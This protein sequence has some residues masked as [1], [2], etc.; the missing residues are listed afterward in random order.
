MVLFPFLAFLAF[1]F[2]SGNTRREPNW[3]A[4]FIQAM[5]M[6]WSYMVAATE[7]L[8][9]F[10]LI[11]RL[12][13]S[14]MWLLVI[15]AFV[16]WFIVMFKR[17]FIFRFPLIYHPASKSIVGWDVLL[18][19]IIF[20][21]LIIGLI[22]PPN[23]QEAMGF[24]MTRVAHW[25]QNRS[26][27]H[28][29]TQDENLNSAPPGI[30]IGLL[31]M[32]VLSGSD[33]W[34]NF[35]PWFAFL[36]CVQAVIAIAGMFGSSA[37]GTRQAAVFGATLPIALAL[38]SG[39]LD[40]LPATLWVVSY[41][42]M[43][44][45]FKEDNNFKFNVFLAAFAAGLAFITKP[46]T[47]LLL[48]PFGIYLFG[49]QI[50]K[51]R[52]VKIL[53]RL[54]WSLVIIL[55]MISGF[56][57]RN[58]KTYG[59][60]FQPSAYFQT[61]NEEYSWRVTVSN[62]LRNFALHADL[63]LPRAES[64]L[65]YHI[66]SFHSKIGMDVND[67]RITAGGHFGIPDMN[68]SETNSGNPLHAIVIIV[69][70][71]VV[72]YTFLKQKN[73]SSRSVMVFSGLLIASF[74]LFN[75]LLKWQPSGS[76]WQLPYFFLFAPIV[77][78]EFDFLNRHKL[79]GGTIISLIL[80]MASIPWLISVKERPLLPLWLFSE[81]K[82][83]LR[84]SRAEMYF[85][86][87]PEDYDLYITAGKYI[88]TKPK[89][90][91][92]GLDVDGPFMEYPLWAVMRTVERHAWIENLSADGESA[93]YLHKNFD[94]SSIFSTHCEVGAEGDLYLLLKKSS[95]GACFFILK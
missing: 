45:F 58:F 13:L 33:R 9:A 4:A 29:A 52:F 49:L 47:V 53:R 19:F 14:L 43:V 23:S 63:P 91:R 79:K 36:G 75:L 76:R 51:I 40:D 94:P 90:Q 56:I 85:N 84:S 62:F 57:I 64:W 20:I 80:F 26:L 77:G 11:T 93:R 88:V 59:F 7:I 38:A 69:S 81:S 61:L 35:I 39:C 55:G 41:V 68:T 30:G 87:N 17:G 73:E 83:I 72:I 92:I 5:I 24:G 10:R 22:A 44:F 65:Q 82:S 37:E 46:V 25:A 78:Y 15:A 89:R 67:P 34:C 1:W 28:F 95:T 2:F 21:P 66:L 3:R 18:A 31:N 54:L 86:T 16:A 74:F 8:G 70:V 27:A 6:W 42:M 12:G 50:G 71:F 48:L 60:A 32:Y